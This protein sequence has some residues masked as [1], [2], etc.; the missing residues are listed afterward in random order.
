[1][2]DRPESQF[3]KSENREC[4]YDSP[5]RDWLSIELFPLSQTDIMERLIDRIENRSAL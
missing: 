1:M 2:T 4:V 5:L 3:S